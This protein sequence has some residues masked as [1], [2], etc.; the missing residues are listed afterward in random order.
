VPNNATPLHNSKEHGPVSQI[1]ADP[2]FI[3]V[4][5]AARLLNL[6]PWY[7]YKLLDERAMESQ[8]AGKRRLVRLES[9]HAYA[10]ALPESPEQAS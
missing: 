10:D 8:Y 2:I 5:E 4:K 9:L 3:S 7:V 1:P 6:T